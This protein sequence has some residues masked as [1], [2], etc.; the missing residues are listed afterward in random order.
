MGRA[1]LAHQFFSQGAY[2]VHAA[3]IH[4]RVHQR[5]PVEILVDIVLQPGGNLVGFDDVVRVEFS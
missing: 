4:Q 1:M 5:Q 2:R 3:D